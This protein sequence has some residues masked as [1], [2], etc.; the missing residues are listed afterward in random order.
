MSQLFEHAT[1]LSTLVQLFTSVSVSMYFQV[2]FFMKSFTTK[3]ADERLV[4][5]MCSHVSV[6]VGRAAKTLFS[7]GAG[8]RFDSSVRQFVVS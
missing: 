6:H 7:Y 8:V 3:V 5:C 1:T 4:V 2:D